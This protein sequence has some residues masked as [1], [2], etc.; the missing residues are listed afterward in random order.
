MSIDEGVAR[1]GLLVYLGSPGHVGGGARVRKRSAELLG[2]GAP[3]RPAAEA[4]YRV[5]VLH[6]LVGCLVPRRLLP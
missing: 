2:A 1:E 6:Q 5:E 4:H 3:G